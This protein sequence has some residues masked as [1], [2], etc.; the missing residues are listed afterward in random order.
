MD[1]VIIDEKEFEELKEKCQ[2]LDRQ[3]IQTRYPNRFTSGHPA[4][5]YNQKIAK[6]CLADAKNIIEFVKKEIKTLSSFE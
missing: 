5:Y 2:E 1:N 3:Y 4:E 6:E